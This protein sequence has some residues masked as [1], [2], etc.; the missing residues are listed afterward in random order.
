MTHIL[1]P[2]FGPCCRCGTTATAVDT[3]IMLPF[4]APIAGH[5]W[6]CL[7]CGLPPDGAIAVVCDACA[8]FLADADWHAADLS[9][10]ES[11]CSGAV[12]DGQR[13]RRAHFRAV[14]FAHDRLQHPELDQTPAAPPA[15]D[16][17][18]L[19]TDR[20]FPGQ[21]DVD[22]DEPCSRCGRAMAES[23]DVPLLLWRANGDMWR[24][25]PACAGWDRRDAG[26]D[27]EDPADAG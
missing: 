25:C 20:L 14:R 12:A 1:D 3:I 26:P 4:Q 6:G 2:L 19:P 16:I 10:L 24:F 15:L 13:M 7:Q 9:L 23:D 21:A 17:Q 11:V 5:G 8:Q 27:A 18:I 22:L